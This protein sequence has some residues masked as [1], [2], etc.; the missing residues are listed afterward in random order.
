MHWHGLSPDI[1]G[2]AFLAGLLVI[3]T[4]VPL[5][6]EV[7][8][9]GII[10]I[11]L[12]IAQIAGIG[13]LLAGMIGLEH[14]RW[15][16]QL[17]AAGA[18]LLGAALLTWTDRR[19][20]D[21]QEAIIGAL[22]VLAASMAILLLAQDPHAGEQ[23]HQ[24]LVGQILWVTPVDLWPALLIYLPVL[25]LWFAWRGRLGHGGFYALFAIT[26]TV[27]VQ[28]VGIYLVFS[29]LIIPALAVRHLGNASGLAIAYAIGIG[30]YAAGLVISGLTDL[31]SGA[32]IVWTL[33]LIA[34]AVGWMPGRRR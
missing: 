32:V 12:A 29:S 31:P 4:H 28:L 8:A 15:S 3:A 25:V 22:F 24:L 10:F 7:L 20:G 27:S 21:A 11:D 14:G 23:L 26:V 5:G 18:A 13:V 2:P 1:L 17:F 9:R 30:G 6:R 33:A 34:V 19:W 16:A